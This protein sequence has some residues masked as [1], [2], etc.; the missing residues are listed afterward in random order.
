MGSKG[1]CLGF[2]FVLSEV[3]SACLNV[4]YL[5]LEA[6][7]AIIIAISFLLL[8]VKFHGKHFTN[9]FSY[10]LGSKYYFYREG[11]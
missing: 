10:V 5:L 11:M 1:G 3:S 9:N 8:P 4:I 2:L 6:I 7:I